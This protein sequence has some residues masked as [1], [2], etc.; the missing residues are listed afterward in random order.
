MGYHI[1]DPHCIGRKSDN[2]FGIFSA[3]GGLKGVTLRGGV[4]VGIYISSI[5][6]FCIPNWL[7]LKAENSPE[8]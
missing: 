1:V 6:F 7:D 4:R 8:I 5:I 2:A 3:G